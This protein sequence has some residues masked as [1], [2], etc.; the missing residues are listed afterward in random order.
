MGEALGKSQIAS[1]G[2]WCL[3]KSGEGLTGKEVLKHL[4]TVSK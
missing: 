2:A 3:S 1:S 4:D